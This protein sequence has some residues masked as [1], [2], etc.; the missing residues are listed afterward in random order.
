MPETIAKVNPLGTEKVGRLMVRFA[1][2]SIIAMLVNSLDNMVDQVFIGQGVGY[3]GNAA[4]SII[5]PLS[6]ALMAIGL[7]IGDGA[8]TFMALNLGKGDKKAAAHGV[9]N[10]IVMI[11]VA[12]IAM[13]V[14]C[15]VFLEPLC[16]LFGA[17]DA[18]LPYALDF[19]LVMVLGFLFGAICC[20]FGG[21]IRADGR[22]NITMI[23]LL[24]GFAVNIIL[25]PLFI[26]VCGWGVTGS[27]LATVTGQG[28]NAAFFAVC[29]FR[30]KTIRLNASCFVPR[31]RTCGRILA[32]GFSSFIAQIVTV[33]VIYFM[34]NL[35]VSYGS[36]SKYGSDIPLAAYGVAVKVSYLLTGIALGLAVGV[37]PILGYNYGSGQYKRV[38]RTFKLALFWSA[39]VCTVG[40]VV[41][42]TW[43]E[44]ISSLFDRESDLYAEFA[45]KCFRICMLL[46]FTIGPGMVSG[47]F[48]Q[49]I[50]KP[51]QAAIL[52][53]SRQAVFLIPMAS[54]FC[55][56]LGVEGVLW[57][58]PFSDLAACIMGLIMVRA[59]WNR[60]FRGGRNE[61]E[62]TSAT[63]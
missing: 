15:L 23:G 19:G 33:V 4:T 14:V 1:V 11:V 12:S 52:T 59:Y 56:F 42:Q 30:F 63:P 26:F 6:I 22:P 31:L 60:L 24:M 57:A 37:Q 48:F 41:F 13:T 36:L 7:M 46:C 16:R 35:L 61:Q 40:F 58:S 45:V 5:L 10:A 17:T 8:A 20:G 25:N 9:G 47:I 49:A 38:K 32:L 51:V 18:V 50:G 62:S 44:Q 27:A 28:L 2:P 21:V 34:N 54:I 53:L 39:V 29:M 43:P 3:L 55:Y